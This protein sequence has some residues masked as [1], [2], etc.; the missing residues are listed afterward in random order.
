VD[1][2]KS[3]SHVE[4]VLV[5]AQDADSDTDHFADATKIET[6][7]EDDVP[8]SALEATA[9][10]NVTPVAEPSTSTSGDGGS[11]SQVQNSG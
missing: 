8:L 10:V 11:T 1:L 6:D 9:F 7:S 2:S 5:D 3:L 4:A